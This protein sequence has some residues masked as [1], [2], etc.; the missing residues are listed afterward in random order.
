RRRR[1]EN[2]MTIRI[3]SMVGAAALLATLGATG[4]AAERA[5]KT[6]PADSAQRLTLKL[7]AGGTVRVVGDGG[8]EIT[9]SYD[10]SATSAGDCTVDAAADADGVTVISRFRSAG[11]RR[12]SNIEIEVHVP[13]YFD[14]ELDSI[15]GGL[16][17]EGVEGEFRGQTMGGALTLRDVRGEARLE[18]MGGAITLVDSELDGKLSTMGGEVL[19]DNVIGDVTGSS[20][21]GNVRYRNV[22]RRD[23][24]VAKLGSLADVD[25][26]EET[27]QIST[28]GGQIS[29]ER[30]AEG[31]ALHTMGGDIRVEDAQR[32][33]RAKT[34][35][36]DI[37]VEAV[38]GWVRATTM[39]GD[40]EVTLVGD[41]GD[42][43]LESMSG[44][45]LLVV[46]PGFSMELDIEIAFTRGS[47]EDYRITSEYDLEQ[48]VSPGWDHAHG[49][50]RKYIRAGG[51][52]GGGD[53]RVKLRTVN[54]NV[55]IRTGG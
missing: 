48:T 45:L 4:T 24:S 32:F 12:G 28:M 26:S 21:G 18:T 29:V 50:P 10:I 39:G 6:F 22:R 41:G 47:S 23:G 33:V 37:V 14:V 9:V 36:G 52:T 1:K 17:L 25:V 20:M 16:E 43:D 5:T 8:S 7:E 40:I 27:V 31:A 49:S 30:A 44:D 55:E 34:M 2:S 19:F 46:P 3:D 15:G 38:D 11:E 54:G 51:R 13:R 35:G 42:V 53:K